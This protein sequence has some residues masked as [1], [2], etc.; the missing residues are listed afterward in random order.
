MN[1]P[2]IPLDTLGRVVTPD[3]KELVLYHR[4]GVYHI[5]VDGMELMSSRAHGSE[6][7]L[8][9]LACGPLRGRRRDRDGL[10]VLV[11]GLGLGYTL[12]SAL[13]QLPGSAVVEVVEVFQAVVDWNRGPLGP[14]AGRPLQDSRVRVVV[15]DLAEHLAAEASLYDAVLLDV[16][17]GPEALTLLS[18]AGLYSSDGLLAIRRRLKPGATLAVWSS[19]PSPRFEKQLRRAGF[20]VRAKTVAARRAAR[21][22]RHTVYVARPRGAVPVR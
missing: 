10:R 16:D 5:R 13:D 7:A 11:G 18:N 12:R 17:N 22:P 19:A 6:E 2:M 21:G 3:G 1:L 14:L 20:A 4:D 8:A 9:E 15:G